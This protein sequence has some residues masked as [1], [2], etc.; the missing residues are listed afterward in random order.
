MNTAALDAPTRHLPVALGLLAAGALL[1]LSPTDVLA[2][3]GCFSPPGPGLVV[4]DAERVLFHR[5]PVTKTTIAWVEVRYSGPAKDFGWVLPLPKPATVGVGSS[6]LFDR[7]D[8]AAAPRFV[9]KRAFEQEGCVYDDV[10]TSGGFGCSSMDMADKAVS[11]PQAANSGG[12]AADEDGQNGVKVL[13]KDQAGPYDY[14][15]IQAKKAEPL[16]KWLNKY[17]YNTPEAA[18]P[19]I[20]SHIEKGDVFVAFKLSSGKGVEEIRPV[21]LEMHDSDP[22]VPLRLTS[23]A[24]S[25]DMNVIVYLLGPGRGVPKN[26]MHVVLNPMKLRWPGGVNNYPQALAAGIDEAAGRAF[27]TEFSAPAKGLQIAA[28]PSGFGMNA[29]ALY[30][31]QIAPLS[32]GGINRKSPWMAGALFDEGFLDVSAF[33]KAQTISG[34]VEAIRREKVLMV[35]DF[36]T[37]LESHTKLAERHG[38]ADVLTWYTQ[39]RAGAINV[40]NHLWNEKVDGESI[41][42]GLKVGIIDPIYDVAQIMKGSAR[43]TR[44]AMRISPQEMDR[45]PMFGFNPDLADVNPLHTAE[46]KQV[47]TGGDS[48]IDATRLTVDGGG[49]Y[50]LRNNEPQF[51]FTEPTGTKTSSTLD[52][53][54]KDAPFALNIEVLEESGAPVPVHESDV[55]LVDQAIAGAIPGAKSLPGDITLKT[56]TKRWAM[57]PDDGDALKAAVADKARVDNSGCTLGRG[58]RGSLSML[59][60]LLLC[61]L[62]LGWRRL[63]SGRVS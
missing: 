17:G 33:A 14:V 44:L 53:R 48:F 62:L 4:Q 26:H 34:I 60:L 47:C 27:V 7:L 12:F 55:K 3:G 50:I 39:L 29:V 28:P 1:V 20:N 52:S 13:A 35:G 38:A 51:T 16:L 36:A 5:D 8:Q 59:G 6:Y 42:Q 43:L 46:V 32:T 57:P 10:A 23:I 22:C 19:I 30:S 37:T 58:V 61:G 9:T 24:A 11:A 63:A 54:W 40:Q 31:Q 18:M 41:A 45:D 2:C 21:T 25:E 49:S 56:V 15:L